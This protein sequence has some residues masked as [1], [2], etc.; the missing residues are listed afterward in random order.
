LFLLM[1]NSILLCTYESYSNAIQLV[2]RE[3]Q[4]DAIVMATGYKHIDHAMRKI[5]GDEVADK[6]TVGTGFD[7]HSE[8]SGVR[9]QI[10]LDNAIC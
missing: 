5:L 7:E 1:V 10:F 4:G 9:I 6:C 3:I 8:L 2:G